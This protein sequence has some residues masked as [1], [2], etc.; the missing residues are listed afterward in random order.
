MLENLPILKAMKKSLFF[1]IILCLAR[2]PAVSQSCLPEGIT[3]QSQSQ[4]DNFHNDYPGCTIIEGDVNF[5]PNMV[6]S[7]VGLNGITAVNGDLNI[8]ITLLNY[9]SGLN[10]LT[11]VGGNLI[12][13]HNDRF[14]SLS[15][16]ENLDSVGG[17]FELSYSDTLPNL[18]GLENLKYVGDTLR[19]IHCDSLANFSGLENLNYVG[20][21]I[22]IYWNN[23]LL[24]LDGLDG[25]ET[26]SSIYVHDNNALTDVSALG[27]LD[28]IPGYLSFGHNDILP[29][30]FGLNGIKAIMGGLR[31]T[32]DDAIVSMAGLDSL[33]YAGFLLLGSPDV[34]GNESLISLAG[35]ENVQHL[36]GDLIIAQNPMLNNLTALA[37]LDSVAGYIEIIDNTSLSN[38][39]GLE[40]IAPQSI[41]DITIIENSMLSECAVES[42]CTYLNSPGTT[43]EIHDNNT[44]CD[45][46]EE[47]QAACKLLST[48]ENQD[49]PACTFYPNPAGDH[50]HFTFRLPDCVIQA[51]I[52]H[53]QQVSLKIYDLQGK[54]IAA[55]LDEMKSAGEYTVR[56]DASILEPGIYFYHLTANGQNSTGK[57]IKIR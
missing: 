23:G 49:R 15:S 33:S 24:S 50:A 57:L 39:D 26:I 52:S 46:R 17:V 28:T 27:H 38:L 36:N 20:N 8:N 55:I 18:N 22:F 11:K 7:L 40:N 6:T 13:N 2:F 25:L 53:N 34:G 9:L 4:I 12:F 48:N 31:V 43:A 51:G 19:L 29:G 32:N 1:V 35:L 16:L 56:F 44:G 41:S 3:F 37:G 42:I 10:S 47:V 14:R 5:A 30:F 54:E 21:L 45:S